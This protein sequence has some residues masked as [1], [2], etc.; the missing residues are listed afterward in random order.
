MNKD[1]VS[2]WIQYAAV[3]ELTQ[4][5]LRKWF[6]LECTPILVGGIL[7]EIRERLLEM[8]MV[9]Y[10]RKLFCMICIFLHLMQERL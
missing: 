2:R 4:V 1:F 6:I 7:R 10:Y 3:T 8:M 9:I 5:M